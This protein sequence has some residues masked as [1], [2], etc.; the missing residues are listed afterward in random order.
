MSSTPNYADR[1][2]DPVINFRS[3][4]VA[5]SKNDD[6]D[7]I[8]LK[9]GGDKENGNAQ[10]KA[11]IEVL[12]AHLESPRGVVI[13]LYVKEKTHEGRTF[14]SAFSFIRAV[15]EPPAGGFGSSSTRAPKATATKAAAAA[16]AAKTIKA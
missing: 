8:T 9:L 12:T 3:V 2:K 5:R 7:R 4:A 1:P 15:Q 14:D 6:A 10:I 11:M 16:F 13:D